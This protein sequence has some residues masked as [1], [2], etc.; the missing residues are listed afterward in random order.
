MIGQSL[1]KVR[2][3]LVRFLDDAASGL[4]TF[5]REIFAK[6]YAQLTELDAHIERGTHRIE[7]LFRTHPVCRKL[8]TVPGSGPLKATAVLA[9][10]GRPAE[11]LPWETSG[12]PG[13]F[14]PIES[15]EERQIGA[16]SYSVWASSPLTRRSF[17]QPCGSRS[18]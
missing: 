16:A 1:E 5:A 14:L 12:P 9:T 7:C 10:I 8:A 13:A 2:P 17:R 15:D 18:P 4:T 3:A 11:P 6:L